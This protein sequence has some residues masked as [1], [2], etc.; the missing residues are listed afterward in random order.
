MKNSVTCPNCNTENP[1]Y[2]STCSKCRNYLRDKI[3]NL[4]L[5]SIISLLIESPSK[6]F[7]K[8]VFAEHKNFIVFILLFVSIKY[9][10]NTR[11]VSMISLGSFKTTVELFYSYLLVAGVIFIFILFFSF[12]FLKAGTSLNISLRYKDTLAL[13]IYAQIPYL[14]GL[15]ILFILELVIF[16]DY[17]FSINPSPFIIKNLLAYLFSGLELAIIIWSAILLFKAFYVQTYSKV[18][19]L[20]SAFIFFVSF[21]LLIYIFSLIVFII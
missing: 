6:A 2:N 3:H 17:L 14:F 13:I 4:D 5:W 12:L 20:I 15:I 8:I 16:G 11:F 7:K 19:S 10:I 9:L 1:F 18:F 21:S